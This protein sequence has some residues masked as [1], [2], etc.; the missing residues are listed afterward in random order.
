MEDFAAD[1]LYWDGWVERMESDDQV[2]YQAGK[3]YGSG[4]WVEELWVLLCYLMG[5]IGYEEQMAL[6]QV[7]IGLSGETGSHGR[8]GVYFL[9]GA[10]GTTH[11]TQH[12]QWVCS[13]P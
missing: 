2:D 4:L 3:Y 7:L 9:G 10:C 6:E 5:E 13:F 8:S 12:I 11:C 1:A